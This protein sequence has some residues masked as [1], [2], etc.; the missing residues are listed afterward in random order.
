MKIFSTGQ[1]NK[2]GD[3]YQFFLIKK[4]HDYKV[5]Y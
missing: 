2:P 4:K 1:D 3:W 5:Q